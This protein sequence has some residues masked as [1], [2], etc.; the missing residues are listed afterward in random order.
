LKDDDEWEEAPSKEQIASDAAIEKALTDN[1][2]KAGD[3]MAAKLRNRAVDEARL[4]LAHNPVPKA[5][6]GGLPPEPGWARLPDYVP[7]PA[8]GFAVAQKRRRLTTAQV[9]ERSAV[10]SHQQHLD[11]IAE[12]VRGLIAEKPTRQRDERI[13]Q[14]LIAAQALLGRGEFDPWLTTIPMSRSAAR[15]LVGAITNGFSSQS[16]KDNSPDI[17]GCYVTK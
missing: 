5:P 3:D 11:K 10:L 4:G 13:G 9:T 8:T 6:G 14:A 1:P 17:T 2:V 12:T 16:S 15:R 7:K